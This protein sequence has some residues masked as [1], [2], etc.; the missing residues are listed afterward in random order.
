[1]GNGDK[2]MGIGILVQPG[3]SSLEAQRAYRLVHAHIA[4][5]SG[6]MQHVSSLKC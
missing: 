2:W 3:T 4:F 5:P 1:M 6:Y